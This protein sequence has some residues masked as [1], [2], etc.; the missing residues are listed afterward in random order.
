M[1]E[2]IVTLCAQASANAGLRWPERPLALL[3]EAAPSMLKMI[4][5]LRSKRNFAVERAPEAHASD[6]YDKSFWAAVPLILRWP[7]SRLRA[8]ALK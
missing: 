2:K 8:H 4:E 6:V 1:D 5:R 7:Y 3:C